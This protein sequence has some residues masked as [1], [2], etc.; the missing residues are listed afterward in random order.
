M[1]EIK[2]RAWDEGNNVMHSNVQFITSGD[3]ENDWIAFASAEVPCRSDGGAGLIFDN[4]F[5]RRQ[6]KLMQYTGIKDRN[7]KEIYESDMVKWGDLPDSQ[8]YNIRIAEVKFN[9]DIQLDCKNIPH[10]HV[11]RW[12]NFAY[13]GKQLEVIG[14]IYEN[15]ELLKK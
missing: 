1:R 2:F 3:G 11:F 14:N 13:G 10:P 6:I 12:G 4:P 8:E 9:P 7:G 15:P 5:F